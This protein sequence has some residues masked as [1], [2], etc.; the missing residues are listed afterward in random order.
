MNSHVGESGI[1]GWSVGDLYPFTI[2]G[3]GQSLQAYNCV[4][5][6]RGLRSYHW[7]ETQEDFYRAH[8]AAQF[9][10]IFNL[11]H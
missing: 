6:E 7:G 9:D 2:R 5:G 8:D 3:V 4:T 10:A 11:V 1:Q